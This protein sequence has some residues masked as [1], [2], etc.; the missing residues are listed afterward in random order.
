MVTHVLALNAY[1]GGS[2]Q[3]FL[4]G[5]SGRSRHR[6]TTLTLPAYKWKWRMRHAAVAFA[7]QISRTDFQISPKPPTSNQFQ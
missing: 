6:F 1:H 2:H 3:A 5:W 7:E 4:N